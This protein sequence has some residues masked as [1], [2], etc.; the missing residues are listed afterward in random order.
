MKALVFLGLATS[1]LLG[2]VNNESPAPGSSSKAALPVCSA[3]GGFAGRVCPV[4]IYALI[5]TPTTYY[6]KTIAFRG[7]IHRSPDGTI[8]VY[9]SSEA[10]ASNDLASAVLCSSGRESC[11]SYAGKYAE[12]FGD[13]T[14][15][16]EQ[17][18]FFKPVG[19]IK[20]T[21]VRSAKYPAER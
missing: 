18:F 11:E 13:F 4:S 16:T 9:P 15:K 21:H 17:D 1:L 12:L 20:L 19:T 7:Y 10:A 14:D 8:I 6:G 2:C 3:Y 5:A